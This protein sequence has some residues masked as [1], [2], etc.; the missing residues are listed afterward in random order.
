MHST[1]SLFANAVGFA[2]ILKLLIFMLAPFGVVVTG[3]MDLTAFAGALKELYGPQKIQ[4]IVYKKNPFFAMLKKFTK[5]TGKNLPVP[6]VYGNP[7]GVG[8]TFATAQSNINPSD[9]AEFLLTRTKYY[10]F[11]KIDHETL[12]ASKDDAGAFLRAKSTEFDGML[13]QLGRRLA[14]SLYGNGSGVVGQIDSGTTLGSTSLQLRDINTV[15]NFEK[16]MIIVL[17][18]AN[19][20]TGSPRAGRLQITKVDRNLGIL[21]VDQ[22][23]NAGIAAATVNDY[24]SFEGDYAKWM[25]GLDAWIPL[26]APGATLFFGVDRSP[27]TTRLGG[28]RMDLTGAPIEEALI[29]LVNRTEREGAELD[30]ILLNHAQFRALEKSQSGKVQLTNPPGGAGANLGFKTFSVNGQSGPVEIFMD[31]NCPNDRIYALQMDTWTLNSLG[32]APTMFNTDGLP[33]LRATNSDD[34][35]ARAYAYPQLGCNAPGYNGVAKVTP[36]P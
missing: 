32:D 31:V 18:A 13:K 28:V 9:I 15:T 7:T 26:T 8:S 27:D 25:S 2:L 33:F 16:D 20:G 19:D 1:G 34:I 10:G 14:I 22:N 30:A 4:Q 35:E 24:I 36:A 12:Q 5:F 29:D 23:I 11:V 6:V 17:T 21:T 3:G